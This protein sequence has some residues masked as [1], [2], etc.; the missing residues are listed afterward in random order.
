MLTAEM[1]LLTEAATRRQDYLLKSYQMARQ[2]IAA[3]AEG[4]PYA[5]A[6]AEKQWDWPTAWDFLERLS[7]A[8]IDVR[9]AR[10]V[11][12]AWQIVR[13]GHAG[14]SRIATLPPL[15]D[16]PAGTAALSQPEGEALR[17]HWLDAPHADGRE[18]GPHRRAFRRGPEAGER[19]SRARVGGR[20]GCGAA[21]GSSRE[22]RVPGH[23]VLHGSRGRRA[24][25][26]RR[27]DRGGQR[28]HRKRR[29]RGQFRAAVQRQ[30]DAGRQRAQARL[31]I[32]APARGTLSALDHQLRRG[33]DR[34][35]A[36][37]L[38]RAL[39]AAA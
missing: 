17:H 34:M 39:H 35:A 13:G 7:L 16:R 22:R 14:D 29:A 18:C 3:G 19:V 36:G 38:S 30:R 23:L 10:G 28:V 9:R 20:Q 32:A 6:I 27:H 37:P 31:R 11:S 25:D 4:K 33:L 26:V 2:A 5:Y 8:G 12:R 1:A 24:L 15:P 21:A